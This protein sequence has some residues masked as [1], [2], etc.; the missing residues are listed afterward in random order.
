[1]F[2]TY[3]SYI[4]YNKDMKLLVGLGNPG[5]KY[6]NTRH[7]LGFMALEQ[8]L[9]DFEPLKDTTWKKSTKLKSDI[10]QI[11]WNRKDGHVEKVLLAKPATYMNNSGMAVRLLMD[12][13]KLSPEDLWVLHDDV[14]FP[15]GSMK[16]RFGGASAGHRGITSII[17]TLGTDKF[18][19]FRMGIGRPKEAGHFGVVHHVLDEFTHEDHKQIREMLKHTSQAIELGLEEDLTA[20]MNRFNTK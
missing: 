18:W 15:A 1:M 8:F 2:V 14:D 5:E 9:K 16:I 6:E 3:I 10:A 19:R 20:A 17:E 11:E 4:L 13:Y 7:N 12:F